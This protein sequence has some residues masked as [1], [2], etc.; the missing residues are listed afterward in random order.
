MKEDRQLKR[1]T[2]DEVIERLKLVL[3][4]FDYKENI[5]FDYEMIT[6]EVKIFNYK[7]DTDVCLIYKGQITYLDEDVKYKQ[8]CERLRD[9]IEEIK[10]DINA[11][12]DLFEGECDYLNYV[13]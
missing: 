5:W 12:Q 10:E 9:V 1:V 11:T 13:K 4:Q 2:E 6:K 8:V 3:K 7:Q